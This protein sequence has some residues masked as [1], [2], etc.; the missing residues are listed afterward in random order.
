MEN[1]LVTTVQASNILGIS[2]ELVRLWC[3]DGKIPAIKLGKTWVIKRVDL[4][5]HPS[6]GEWQG[7]HTRRTKKPAD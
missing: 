1:D 2:D 5:N 7:N 6:V 3:R 4:E